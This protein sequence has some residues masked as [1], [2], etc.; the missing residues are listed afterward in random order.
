MST[1]RRTFLRTAAAAVFGTLA[2]FYVPRLAADVR[3]SL[4]M[5]GHPSGSGWVNYTAT[6][7]NVDRGALIAKMKE[8]WSTLNFRAPFEEIQ[9]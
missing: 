9:P 8:S 4:P 3:G 1:T 6:Y 7:S 2:A 5:Q